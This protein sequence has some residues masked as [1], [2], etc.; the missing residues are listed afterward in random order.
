MVEFESLARWAGRSSA[1]PPVA[2]TFS[3]GTIEDPEV[4]EAPVDV[5][6]EL[7]SIAAFVCIIE[8]DGEH[9]LITCRRF[10]LVGDLGYVG[11]VCHAAR[12]YRQFRCD[13][14]QSVFD[15]SSGEALGDGGFFHRFEAQ[16][17][18]E[19]AASGGLTPSQKATLIAGLN[20]RAFMA[21]CAGAGIRWRPPPLRS[22]YA[23]CGFA[24]KG[25]EIRR[26]TRSSRIRSGWRRTRKPS[27]APSS[28][29]PIAPPRRRSSNDL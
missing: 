24:R 3:L 27:S 2:A 29:M 26:W 5:E 7:Q 9:R 19:H 28:I 15:A 17:R 4:G 25:L 21:R 6:P 11:A 22:S 10:D 8:Y 18:R 16:S 23:R 12:G 13:R 14:I 20:V 1:L